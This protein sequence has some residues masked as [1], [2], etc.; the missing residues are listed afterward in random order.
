MP[1][2]AV[3][4]GETD[5]SLDLQYLEDKPPDH[6][7]AA[8]ETK[9]EAS[10]NVA[11]EKNQSTSTNTATNNEQ[12]EM[13]ILVNTFSGIQMPEGMRKSYGFPCWR[14]SRGAHSYAECFTLHKKNAEL[15]IYSERWASPS[16]HVYNWIQ[17][18]RDSCRQRPL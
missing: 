16:R 6:A 17:L 2:Q 4:Y 12:I 8:A 11:E 14:C 18:C 5:I 15:C 9:N 10:S 3:W 13:G 7:A 1:T